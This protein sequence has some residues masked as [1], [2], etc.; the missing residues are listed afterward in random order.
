MYIADDTVATMLPTAAPMMVPL[1]PRVERMTAEDT[2]A[3]AE[4]ITAT[5]SSPSGPRRSP[6]VASMPEWFNARGYPASM[7]FDLSDPGF[8]TTAS[9][10]HEA[11][12]QDWVVE[13]NLGWAVLRH[14]EAAAVLKDRRFQQG[15]ARWPAQNGIHSGLFSDW[16]QETL[17]SLEG[18][19]HSRIRRLLTPAF[20]SRTIAAMRPRFQALANELIDGFVGRGRVEFVSEFAEPYA[21]RIICVLLGLAEEEWSRSRVGPTTWAAASPSTWP[22]TCR[23]SR[24]R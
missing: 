3:R 15:N 1:A 4:P 18:D 21:S 24:L 19:D 10:V 9:A 6:M 20:R 11:R 5:Q 2:A 13:T 7:A 22:T 16:W 14:A 23:A 8:D 17:L 12:E